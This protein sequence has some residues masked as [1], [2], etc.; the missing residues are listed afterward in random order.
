LSSPLGVENTRGVVRPSDGPWTALALKRSA[1][2]A[3]VA[4][5][6]GVRLPRNDAATDPSSWALTGPSDPAS[7]FAC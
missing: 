6:A 1:A 2:V 3:G 5:S 7:S 4:L